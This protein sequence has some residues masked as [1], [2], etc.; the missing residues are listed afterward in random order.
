MRFRQPNSSGLGERHHRQSWTAAHILIGA[1]FLLAYFKL[2]DKVST[3]ILMTYFEHGQDVLGFSRCVSPPQPHF[4]FEDLQEILISVPS[5]K[6][7]R[8][9]NLHYT[10]EPH[11]LGQGEP[12]AIW[13]QQKWREFGVENTSIDYFP[14]PIPLSRP[15]SQRIALLQRDG[16]GKEVS[17]LYVARLME[18]STYVNPVSGMIVATP[19]FAAYAPSG[20]VTARYVLCQFW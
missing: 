15:K 9:W 5:P 1:T 4:S 16:Q 2:R 13:T 3:S 20:N 12:H 7:A 11:Y 10:S 8:E 14:V 17:E 6:K 19:Q 18:T